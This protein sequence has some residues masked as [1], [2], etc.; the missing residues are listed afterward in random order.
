M[1]NPDDHDAPPADLLARARTLIEAAA[2]LIDAAEGRLSAPLPAA[3]DGAAEAEQRAAA[4]VDAR[5]AVDLHELV[6]STRE[7]AQGAM[8]AGVRRLQRAG[9]SRDD[10]RTETGLTK[11]L[12]KWI[13][14]DHAAA[15]RARRRRQSEAGE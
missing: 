9:M 8:Y 10:M 7:K 11:S 3:D 6:K 4:A 14:E 5:A 13:V 1:T 2:L 12:I 15:R